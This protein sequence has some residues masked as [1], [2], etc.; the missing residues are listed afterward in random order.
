VPFLCSN[1]KK[2]FDYD[3]ITYLNDSISKSISTHMIDCDPTAFQ[4]RF[5]YIDY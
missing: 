3:P 5:S 2:Q 4:P 1:T